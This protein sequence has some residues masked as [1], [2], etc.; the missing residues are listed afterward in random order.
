MRSPVLTWRM[1]LLGQE[2]RE[3]ASADRHAGTERI[4]LSGWLL[5]REI[6]HV[7]PT[8][9]VELTF[10]NA[11]RYNPGTSYPSTVHIPQYAVCMLQYAW[12]WRVCNDPVRS[13]HKLRVQ[14]RLGRQSA[15]PTPLLPGPNLSTRMCWKRSANY[16][17]TQR[18]LTP[19]P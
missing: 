7:V 1:A 10:E 9:E 5:L 13:R 11:M 15:L 16:K 12:C 14:V 6:A 18:G 8:R 19:T 2:E 17:N 3:Y 4:V